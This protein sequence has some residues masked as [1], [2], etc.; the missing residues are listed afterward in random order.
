MTLPD[1]VDGRE[2]V[3]GGGPAAAAFVATRAA[4]GYSRVVVVNKSRT[5]GGIFTELVKFDLNSSNWSSVASTA[6]PGPTRI[7]PMS[8]TDDLNLI[9]N[10]QFQVRDKTM[11]EY[12]DSFSMARAVRETL[13]EYADTYSNA[14]LLY[15]STGSMYSPE[16]IKLGRARR[17]IFAGGLVPKPVPQGTAIMSGY[18]FLRSPVR[19]LADKKIAV[20]GDGAT[21]AQVVELMV[22]DSYMKPVTL[23][24]NIHWF[25]GP[26]M[27]LTKSTWMEYY[28]ARFSGLGRHF[29][30]SGVGGGIIRPF[31]V[32]GAVDPA[33][34]IAVVNQEVFDL[35]VY[36]PGF[37]PAPCPVSMPGVVQLGG[38]SVARSSGRSDPLNG[39]VFAIG[40]A[41]G[42]ENPYQPYRTRFSASNNALYVNL[43]RIAAFAGALP[44]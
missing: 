22:G 7:R 11:S 9:P 44:R 2:V 4:L 25:G 33:G 40:A 39:R 29:P 28:H 35:V 21:A 3:L 8:P 27:L 42:F 31:D 37:D 20:I 34:E 12:P 36:C 18:E 14:E 24:G 26:D 10:S 41:A 5:L 1:S 19:Y 32:R 38:M 43:P 13:N 17:I 23:P 30:Q 15:D 6:S 16:G